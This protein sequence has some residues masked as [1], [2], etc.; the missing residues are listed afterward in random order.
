M[1]PV[2][3]FPYV[4]EQA[5]LTLNVDLHPDETGLAS[6]AASLV[7]CFAGAIGVT[8]LEPLMVK[9]GPGWTSTFIGLLGGFSIPMLLVLRVMGPRWRNCPV[10]VGRGREES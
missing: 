4:R 3:T 8:F 2:N 9:V 5:F 6:V 10:G 7:R 1:L